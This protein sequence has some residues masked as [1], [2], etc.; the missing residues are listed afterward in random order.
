MGIPCPRKGATCQRATHYQP[1][2]LASDDLARLFASDCPSF[3][4]F[5]LE[6][7]AI[8]EIWLI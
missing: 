1:T 7:F 5:G 3:F 2:R 8:V 6:E 4:R